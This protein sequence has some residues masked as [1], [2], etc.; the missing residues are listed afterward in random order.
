MTFDEFI[1]QAR[2][3]KKLSAVKLLILENL[4]ETGHAFPRNWVSSAH[5]LEITGQ[6]YF[7]R[8]TREL[9]D[10]VGLDIETKHINGQHHYRLRSTSLN[11]ANPRQYL[12]ESDKKKLFV[13]AGYK[14]AICGKHAQ[15]GVRGLQADHKVPLIRGGIQDFENWQSLCN[16]CNVSKRRSCQGCEEKCSVCSWAFPATLGVGITVR[17]LPETAAR[18]KQLTSDIPKWIEEIIEKELDS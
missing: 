11:Q 4:W 5:L 17:L 1:T 10:E 12:S 7:D 6:K 18:I 3:G 15:P 16:D 13:Q 14:C 9:R 2:Q 8:R